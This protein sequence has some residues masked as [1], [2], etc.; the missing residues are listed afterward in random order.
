MIM[1][2]IVAALQPSSRGHACGPLHCTPTYDRPLLHTTRVD[3]HLQL[4]SDASIY[5]PCSC[6]CKNC[7]ASCS[8]S[9]C[10]PS[11]DRDVDRQRR[12]VG[13]RDRH[14]RELASQ[15]SKMRPKRSK[16]AGLC[17][18]G[19]LNWSMRGQRSKARSKARGAAAAG[20]RAMKG[21]ESAGGGG[22][23]GEKRSYVRVCD[24]RLVQ[25]SVAVVS[26]AFFMVVLSSS[27]AAASAGASLRV[28]VVVVIAS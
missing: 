15:I 20:R 25:L 4:Q 18:W 14:V 6:H 19:L 22:W 10:D 16:G 5:P 13:R 7:H 21:R 24:G 26:S 2:E 9:A 17:V 27:A 11:R 12:T 8:C 28:V 1:I 3:V 23:E